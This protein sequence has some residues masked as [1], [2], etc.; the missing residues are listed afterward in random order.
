MKTK[1]YKKLL[2]LSIKNALGGRG[3]ITDDLLEHSRASKEDLTQT[4]LITWMQKVDADFD[5]EVGKG[6]KFSEFEKVY[7]EFI[8]EGGHSTFLGLNICEEKKSN[9]SIRIDYKKTSQYNDDKMT[10]NH[11]ALADNYF[12]YYWDKYNKETKIWLKEL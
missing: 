10:Y 7:N 9:G 3:F 1:N 4:N 11:L 8:A 12:Y 5:K 6:K 2:D